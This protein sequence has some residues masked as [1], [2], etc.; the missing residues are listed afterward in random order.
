M[1]RTKADFSAGRVG[2]TFIAPSPSPVASHLSPGEFNWDD[3]ALN[4]QRKVAPYDGHG[5]SRP[6]RRQYGT[7][8]FTGATV[9]LCFSAA[10][11]ATLRCSDQKRRNALLEKRDESPRFGRQA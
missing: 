5:V 1:S 7:N 6:A 10:V 8:R 9:R 11:A 3:A 4:G 2:A